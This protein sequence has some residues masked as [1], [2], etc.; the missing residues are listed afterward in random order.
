MIR[1][2]S[3]VPNE[4]LPKWFETGAILPLLYCV[5]EGD[6]RENYAALKGLQAGGS[7]QKVLVPF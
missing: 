4:D 1:L 2:A 3:K 5:I 6:V 7:K